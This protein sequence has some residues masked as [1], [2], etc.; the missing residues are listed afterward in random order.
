MKKRNG[1]LYDGMWNLDRYEGIGIR[2][3]IN[4]NVYKGN[5]VPEDVFEGQREGYG[6]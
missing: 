3:Y 1:D 2:K 6:E 5:W 4:G